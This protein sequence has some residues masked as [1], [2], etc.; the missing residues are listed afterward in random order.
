[1]P[2]KMP[3]LGNGLKNALGN[4]S[5]NVGNS[6]GNGL[7]NSSGIGLGNSL[8]NGLGHISGILFLINHN[9]EDYLSIEKLSY[10]KWL[11]KGGL[12]RGL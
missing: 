6:F 9:S 7:G 2:Q 4:S 3:A 1:M 10:W 11:R 12:G 8:G 5:G